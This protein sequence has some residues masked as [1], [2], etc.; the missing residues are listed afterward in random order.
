MSQKLSTYDF[1]IAVTDPRRTDHP[2]LFVN[3]AYSALTGYS[4]DEVVGRNC[5][6]LQGDETERRHIV[7]M[8]AAVKE[9]R[10]CQVLHL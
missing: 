5:R 1:A 9:E 7:E 4:V 8:R 6:F 2:I 3:Q 10:P